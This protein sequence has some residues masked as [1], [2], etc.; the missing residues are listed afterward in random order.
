[1]NASDWIAHLRKKKHSPIPGSGGAEYCGAP[2]DRRQSP[3]MDLYNCF[4][5]EVVLFVFPVR[6]PAKIFK[7]VWTLKG[8]IAGIPGCQH[9]AGIILLFLTV[10]VCGECTD[11]P[12]SERFGPNL[13]MND[14][15]KTSSDIAR[16]SNDQAPAVPLETLRGPFAAACRLLVDRYGIS[17]ESAV[18]VVAA[19]LATA[20]GPTVKVRDPFGSDLL[21][22]FEFVVCEHGPSTVTA[23][24][25]DAFRPLQE[26]VRCKLQWRAA[27]GI[28]KLE[29]QYQDA[30]R[31]VGELEK[32]R[33][34]GPERPA[35]PAGFTPPD[36]ATV[37]RW[38]EEHRSKVSQRCEQLRATVAECRVGL[39]PF[40]VGRDLSW[41]SIEG[42]DEVVFDGGLTAL[43]SGA[44]LEE[45][46]ALPS[47]RL[48]AISKILRASRH[49]CPLLRGKS[50]LLDP[51][52]VILWT[53][54]WSLL[55]RA[56]SHRGVL[57][58]DAIGGLIIEARGAEIDLE[59]F[60]AA[61]S[62][63]EWDALLAK[64]FCLRSL[65]VPKV[66]LIDHG[67]AAALLGFREWSRAIDPDG[68][69]Q[70][71]TAQWPATMLKFALCF[72]VSSGAANS[73]T[74]DAALVEQ[75]VKVM[76]DLCN[77]QLKLVGKMLQPTD[78]E[79]DKMVS[80]LAA[81]GGCLTKRELFRSY[82]QQDYG[83]LDVVLAQAEE[84]GAI[85]RDGRLLRLAGNSVSV[86]ASAHT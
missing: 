23:A 83:V 48:Q 26:E 73:E 52:V 14:T 76:K 42:I 86:S 9:S 27:A 19:T 32:Q 7:P 82:S 17:R 56:F 81:K 80:K 49:G 28:R 54:S 30:L 59:R 22:S 16:N 65:G 39:K 62:D 35:T 25:G 77:N 15:Q 33:L 3:V 53:V 51:M 61:S 63:P 21:M 67:G 6:T 74:I 29:A 58:S 37:A 40:F 78:D 72:H 55:R 18:V 13:T 69:W 34:I 71:F 41:E 36:P 24:I 4:D 46:L 11:R 75:A 8:F 43:S 38:D 50:A 66:Y 44:M 31:E 47:K 2:R 64:L 85:V 5:S 68:L 1:M 84:A 12:G 57:E 45:L 79:V 70:R 10:N 20:V 60:L